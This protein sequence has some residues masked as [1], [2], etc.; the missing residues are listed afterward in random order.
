MYLLDRNRWI[1][2]HLKCYQQIYPVMIVKRF[3]SR[4]C[5]M[6]TANTVS[7]TSDEAAD[8]KHMYK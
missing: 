2:R 7:V 1:R 6:F 3:S 8:F 5:Y 4:V